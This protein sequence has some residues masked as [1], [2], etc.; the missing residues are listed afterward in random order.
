MCVRYDNMTLTLHSMVGRLGI[1]VA[2]IIDLSGRLVKSFL[3][4]FSPK[5]VPSIGTSVGT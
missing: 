3:Q 2:P 4:V 5:V 1:V